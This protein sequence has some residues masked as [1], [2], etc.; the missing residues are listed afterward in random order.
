MARWLALLLLI[1]LLSC[2]QPAPCP[3]TPGHLC[4][5]AQSQTPRTD[6]FKL[7]RTEVRVG[8]CDARDSLDQPRSGP[9][10]FLRACPAAVTTP[11][12]AL[13]IV[14][15]PS[16]SPGVLGCPDGSQA[17][18][19]D[20][21]AGCPVPTRS[22]SEITAN[23]DLTATPGA[24]R[25]QVVLLDDA[26]TCLEAGAAR[27]GAERPQD[28]NVT[29]TLSAAGCEGWHRPCTAHTQCAT[30]GQIC[31]NS[32]CI[33]PPAPPGG[34]D[35]L[36]GK[37][38]MAFI[39][40]G[41]IVMGH[42]V[43]AAREQPCCLRSGAAC[44]PAPKPSL[45]VGPY[46][47]DVYEAD[48]TSYQQ[49]LLKNPAQSLPGLRPAS[50][51]PLTS[52]PDPTSP[53]YCTYFKPGA[54]PAGDP[55]AADRSVNCLNFRQASDYCAYRARLDEP[56]L[57]GADTQGGL[58]TEPEWEWVAIG[59]RSLPLSSKPTLP[60]GGDAV[61]PC[62][63]SSPNY[64][65]SMGATPTPCQTPTATTP[66][67]RAPG[68]SADDRTFAAVWPDAVVYDL[69]G[70]LSEWTA[71]LLPLTQ[72]YDYCRIDNSTS[73]PLSV[74]RGGTWALSNLFVST[75]HRDSRDGRVDAG[76]PDD[77]KTADQV[78]LR[79]VL[80]LKTDS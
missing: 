75:Y 13:S 27:F 38:A 77:S 72:T 43:G 49:F 3:A 78:G 29:V 80:R 61:P 16:Q 26:G 79:C 6:K 5:S 57:S 60:A 24:G 8:D 20:G 65:P 21:V 35:R 31:C 56:T 7:L 40:A 2:S 44:E 59:G 34:A 51:P 33:G 66:P 4:I 74:V 45:D 68:T 18:V 55:G 15:T 50:Y 37:R 32:R 70:N 46:Y 48:V 42:P 71:T 64:N 52:Y 63:A 41:Q 36:P 69:G 10:R 67:V 54:A 11:A 39:P 53:L 62:S 22:R 23:I 76:H 9:E 58:P 1:P 73:Y 30:R 12:C 17:S 19:V 47:V 28:L 14:P 25:V